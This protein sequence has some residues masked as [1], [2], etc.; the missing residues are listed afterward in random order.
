MSEA[1]ERILLE[2]KMRGPSTVA[3]MARLL[4]VT[5]MAVRQHLSVL[6]EDGFVEF[7]EEKG[8]V[9]RPRRRWRL[10]NNEN[11]RSRFPDSH[12]DLSLGLIE[13]VRSAFGEEGLGR[14]VAE[15]N[16]ALEERYRQHIPPDASTGDRIEALARIRRDEGYMAE[17]SRQEDGTWLLIENHCPIC[18]AADS[19]RGLCR[20]ELELFQAVLGNELDICRE[21]H[22]L[23]GGRRCTYRVSP[24]RPDA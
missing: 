1:K 6:E 3:R 2:L 16:R 24:A 11:V 8:K 13:A 21:E 18:V 15:R 19:C 7:D 5:A 12:A 17:S 4:G 10:Q 23:S 22:I 14:L 20:G 9:G